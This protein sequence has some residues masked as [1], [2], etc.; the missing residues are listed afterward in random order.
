MDKIIFIFILYLGSLY[1]KNL[2]EITLKIN[3]I[4]VEKRVDRINEYGI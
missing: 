1:F 2:F 4:G 3:L